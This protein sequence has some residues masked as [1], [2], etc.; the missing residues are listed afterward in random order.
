MQNVTKMPAY[1][2]VYPISMFAVVAAVALMPLVLHLAK[3]SES[4]PGEALL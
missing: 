3:V 4:Q 2:L 1:D